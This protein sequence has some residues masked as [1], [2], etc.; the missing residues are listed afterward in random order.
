MCIIDYELDCSKGLSIG[1]TT[2][3]GHHVDGG[4][5]LQ[6]QLRAAFV[7]FKS[8][9]EERRSAILRDVDASDLAHSDG[10]C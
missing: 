6:Q 8:R 1:G 9:H 2:H 4:L 7:A 10:R 3:L 5:G